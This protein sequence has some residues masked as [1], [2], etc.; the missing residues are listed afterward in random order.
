[1]KRHYLALIVILLAAITWTDCRRAREA[2]DNA[3]QF[4][5]G[6]LFA[7]DGKGDRSYNDMALQ[8]I[9]EAHK[10]LEFETIEVQPPRT[11]DYVSAIRDLARAGVKLIIGVGFLYSEPV[12][13]VAAEY[14]ST[15]FVVVDGDAGGSANVRSIVFRPEEGCYLVGAIAA[16]KSSSKKIGFIAGMDI[17]IMRKFECGFV[18]GAKKIDPNITIVRQ[19]IGSTPAA[20][21]D[22]AK[23]RDVALL[24]YDRGV[25]VIFHA[26]GASGNGVIQAAKERRK[27]VIGVDADQ[28]WM[29]P[30]F[31]L[32]SMRKRID[33]SV[34]RA[35]DDAINNR[36]T[37][38][39]R[40]LGLKEDGIDYV[41]KGTGPSLI[42]DEL[43]ESVQQMRDD[44]IRGKVKVCSQ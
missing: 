32:T 30:D 25:D 26:A 21:A 23:G 29:A 41:A 44:V 40:T 13:T 28:S 27:W 1:M 5:V 34:Q 17:P 22:P 20:F 6:L 33:I 43:N 16:A 12:K 18:Q 7:P 9:K 3:P 35:I 24:M 11:A 39:V 19:Y 37:G 38:G 42:P 4:K 14:P 10:T 31:V 36:F 15:K 8:G 2:T